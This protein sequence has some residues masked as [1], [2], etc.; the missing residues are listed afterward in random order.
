M[1]SPADDETD[2]TIIGQLRAQALMEGHTAGTHAFEHRVDQLRVI[3]CRE[4]RGHF[5]CTVCEYYDHCEL[6]KKVL[7]LNHGLE[8]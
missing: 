6:V 3:R 5:A 1:A 4:F 7:R 2:P 8:E